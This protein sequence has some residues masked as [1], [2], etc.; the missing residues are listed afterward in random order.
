MRERFTDIAALATRTNKAAVLVVQ[1]FPI[2]EDDHGPRFPPVRESIA[3]LM[4]FVELGTAADLA[5][6][7]A[8]AQS[9]N[10][11]ALDC[12]HKLVES[13]S[14]VETARQRVNRSRLLY[15]SDNQVW[16]QSAFDM[17]QRIE[18]GLSGR[19]VALCGSGPIVDALAASLTQIGA[20]VRRPDAGS[21]P[22][23][24]PI[25]LGASQKRC[26]IDAAL[27]DRLPASASIYDLG[28][29]NL[30]L[31]A[32]SRARA[33][34]C[35]LYRL[36]NRAGISSAIIGLLETDHMIAN[37]MGRATLRGIEVVAGGLLGMPGAVIVDDIRR[38]R[39]IFGVADGAGRFRPE[40]LT[41][42]DRE[43]VEY[44]RAL[45]AE[46]R[47]GAASA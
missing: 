2:A 31:D 40:P 16:F 12:D 45:I 47:G 27:V 6:V 39:V 28:L 19:R 37:L 21:G 20:H 15:Y 30:S 26:S 14:I 38:P 46:A 13:A 24:A 35:T 43:R 11:I 34:G 18:H 44:V 7:L 10:W 4:A 36:D 23:D 33:R 1:Q 22:L 17:V 25:V 8:E 29:G 9:F 41:A 42:E 3:N 32:A 5:A